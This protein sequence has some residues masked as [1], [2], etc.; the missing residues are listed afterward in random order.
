MKSY[1]S[2]LLLACTVTAAAQDAVVLDSTDVFFRHIELKQVVV[3][4]PTGAAKFSG[5][6]KGNS[7]FGAIVALLENETTEDEVIAKMCAE[8]DAPKEKIAEDVHTAIEKLRS[9][10]AIDD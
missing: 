4:G 9:I 7:T 1:F 2:I 10:G 5:L 8:Y 3:T 6:V